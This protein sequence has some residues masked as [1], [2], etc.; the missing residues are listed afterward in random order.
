MQGV[1]S[2]IA[3]AHRIPKLC[4]AIS[5]YYEQQL[6]G[7]RTIY[8]MNYWDRVRLQLRSSDA[9]NV[10]PLVPVLASASTPKLPFGLCNFVLVKRVPELDVVL[11]QGGQELFSILFY[12]TATQGTL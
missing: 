9:M 2:Q 10:M 4:I 1:V 11:L 8:L 3:Q 6:E 7:G 5:D 12:L